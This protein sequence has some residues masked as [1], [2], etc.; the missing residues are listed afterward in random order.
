MEP[1]GTQTLR[2]RVVAFLG[3]SEFADFHVDLVTNVAMTGTPEDLPPLVPVDIPGVERVSYRVYPVVDHIADKVC[4]LLEKHVRASGVEESSSRYRDLADL[5]TFAHSVEVDAELL[6]RAIRS[7]AA[8]RRLRLPDGMTLPTSGDWTAGYARVAR[9]VPGLSER[10]LSS[11]FA[12]A[13]RFLD[14]VLASDATGCWDPIS[15]SWK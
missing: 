9:D 14:P 7:E 15:L 3:A 8:R 5:V 1:Q 12:T 6:R 13:S 4:A 11:A 10:D 2:I